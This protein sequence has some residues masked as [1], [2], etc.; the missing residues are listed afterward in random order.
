MQQFYQFCAILS[1]SPDPLGLYSTSFLL[2]WPSTWHIPPHL[3]LQEKSGL[4]SSGMYIRM[5]GRHWNRIFN[6]TLSQGHTPPLWHITCSL[7]RTEQWLILSA[8]PSYGIILS[9]EQSLAKPYSIIDCLYGREFWMFFNGSSE[10][11]LLLHG[12]TNLQHQR[13]DHERNTGKECVAAKTGL[14]FR[15]TSTGQQY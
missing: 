13:Q 11:G 5:A 12:N 3:S 9:Q 10:V 1:V 8:F 14:F 7:G 2:I 6:N 4:Q 15:Y